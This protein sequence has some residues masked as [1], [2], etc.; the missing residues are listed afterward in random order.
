MKNLI[1]APHPDDEILGLGGTILKKKNREK[2]GVLYVT[3]MLDNINWSK[4]QIQLREKEIEKVRKFFKF[5]FIQKLGFPTSQLD[6][7]SKY[8]IINKINKTIKIFKPDR[9]FVPNPTDSHSDHKVVFDA[10]AACSKSFRNPFVK[11]W[12]CYEVLSETE[13]SLT[14]NFKPNYFVK[15]TKNH[16]E[17]KIKS[18]KIYKSEYGIFPFPRSRDSIIALAKFRG[19]TVNTEFAEAFCIKKLID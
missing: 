13:Q 10:S 2:F 18:L 16:I 6:I 11:Q 1:I 12:I 14:N 3:S 4:K 19:T 7:I 15:L 9:V 8:E 17:K 5:D